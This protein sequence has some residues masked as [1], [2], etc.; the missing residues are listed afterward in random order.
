MLP[1]LHDHDAVAKVGREHPKLRG[2]AIKGDISPRIFFN[3]VLTI[4]SRK[5]HAFHKGRMERPENS[6][7][8]SVSALDVRPRWGLPALSQRCHMLVRWALVKL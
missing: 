1:Q 8:P 6:L 3:A 2:H 4:S 5:C 7:P